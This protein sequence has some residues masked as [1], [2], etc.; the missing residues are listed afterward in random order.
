M[1][2][3]EWLKGDIIYI[4]HDYFKDKTMVIYRYDGQ[5]YL[6]EL[7]TPEDFHPYI[8]LS[9]NGIKYDK[10]KHCNTVREAKNLKKKYTENAF[11]LNPDRQ[12]LNQHNLNYFQN[13][14][15]SDLR[16]TIFDIE[17]TS[18]DPETGEIIALGILDPNGF[19]IFTEKDGGERKI[20]T[21]FKNYLNEYDPD[22][23][24][25]HN[26]F[27]FDL[28][29]IEQRMI[30]HGIKTNIGKFGIDIQKDLYKSKVNRLIIGWDFFQYRIPGRYIIDTMHLSM[31]EDV[32][33]NEFESYSLKYLA[34]L[35]DIAPDD[36][37]YI[38]GE[39]IKNVYKNDIEQ[40]SKYLKDDLTETYAL[41]RMFL[42][43]YFSTSKIIP[44]DLQSQL[45]AGPTQ[46]L[47]ALFARDYYHAKKMIPKPKSKRKYQGAIT[48]A[49]SFGIFKNI[50][51][52][53]VS[54]LYPSEMEVYNYF[55]ESD[56][57]GVMKKYLKIFKTERLK[58][59]ELAEKEKEAIETKNIHS[60]VFEEY[61]AYQL[62][63]KILINSFYGV[64]ANEFFC[65]ND[66]NAAENVAKKGREVLTIMMNEIIKS[67][68]TLI[69]VDTD[70][71]MFSFPSSVDP[72]KLLEHINSCL[73]KGINVE[74]EKSWPSMIS[75]KGKTYATLSDKGKL[76]KKGAAFKS[77]GL[78]PFL[79][80]F[81]ES[82]LYNA[83]NGSIEKYKDDYYLLKHSIADKTI[84]VSELI[85]S[86]NLKFDWNHYINRETGGKIAPFEAMERE[87]LTDRYKAGDKIKF[88]YSG[89]KIEKM[90][91]DMV[92]L[93]LGQ[94]TKD[95][96]IDYYIDLLNKWD[97]IF[98]TIIEN[99]HEQK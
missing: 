82:F 10:L 19:K 61:H 52:Y 65:W 25:G 42:P 38:E 39:E 46:K 11:F 56:T 89:D 21:D 70:G 84:S 15:L 44:M 30:K 31:I 86:Q 95:Y 72:Y 77:R 53:D 24:C 27:S 20:L 74:F 98:Q 23:L 79:S 73:D 37:V 17:T 40:F 13:L 81:I 90:K 91:S 87:N 99:T 4:Y 2:S 18:L 80:K 12:F 32:R 16:T 96:N 45:Y 28:P 5:D 22:I 54:S 67:G 97:K 83:L 34:K 43:S 60:K 57:L 51:K 88:Y 14:F 59:K 75:Y 94:D 3:I 50:A 64:L 69:S 9:T 58:F 93:Y 62:A 85:K 29:F 6:Q 7:K 41:M 35:L 71:A 1:E 68:C 8:W 92:K 47:H 66:Y 48:E 78:Q 33:R 63:L 26:I 49:V 76:M 36:R 55:P